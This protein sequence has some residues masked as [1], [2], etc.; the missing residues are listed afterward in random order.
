MKRPTKNDRYGDAMASGE[1]TEAEFAGFLK[2]VFA[3]LVEASSDGSIHFVAMDWRHI[4]EVM[5]AASGTYS[6]FKNLCIYG[7][8]DCKKDGTDG[9]LHEVCIHLLEKGEQRLLSAV[10][11]NTFRL[12]S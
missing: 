4:A 9:R 3:S 7:R 11:T 5:T 2:L 1:M 12:G 10:E 8:P 6:E